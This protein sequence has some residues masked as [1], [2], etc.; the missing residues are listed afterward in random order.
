MTT[1]IGFYHLI[2]WPLDKAL[3]KLLEKVLAS[4][5]R[6][7][8]MAGSSERIEHLNAL[9]WTYDPGSWLPHGS[10]SD[11]DA[12][13]QPVWLTDQDENPNQ[14]TVLVLTDGVVTPLIDSFERCL[15]LFDGRD[16]QAV[17]AARNRW[18]MWKAA[19]HD[20]TYLQ[21]TERGGWEEKARSPAP[22]SDN[23]ED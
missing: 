18:R 19:G 6:A 5:Q 21:Q 14:A 7:V 1:R 9:L 11:G 22:N 15:D 2:H 10:R 23:Q 20:L 16:P 4:G 3:P 12:A 8:V 13:L 17:E